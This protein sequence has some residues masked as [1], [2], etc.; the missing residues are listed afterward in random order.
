MSSARNNKTLQL[1]GAAKRESQEREVLTRFRCAHDNRSEARAAGRRLRRVAR[2]R[3]GGSG[4]RRQ[5][6]QEG[7]APEAAAHS[8]HDAAAPGARGD[9]HAQPVSRHV[10]QRGDRH[11]D[12]PLRVESQGEFRQ[13]FF[14]PFPVFTYVS[15]NFGANFGR[16][17]WKIEN[18]QFKK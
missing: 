17:H 16:I 14:L 15:Y 9:I 18:A 13:I 1:Y 8:L 4:R 11:V 3:V 7:Q 10:H 6:R 5:G 2:R 12:E